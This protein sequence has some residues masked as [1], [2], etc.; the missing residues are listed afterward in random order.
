M[1]VGF[2]LQRRKSRELTHMLQLRYRFPTA[3]FALFWVWPIR[4][5]LV[6]WTRVLDASREECLAV[7]ETLSGR[8]CRGTLA[9]GLCSFSSRSPRRGP[10]GEES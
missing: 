3:S 2:G 1:N 7:L 5:R 6:E 9:F 8:P 4:I 10:I